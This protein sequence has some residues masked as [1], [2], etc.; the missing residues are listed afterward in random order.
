MMTDQG[1]IEG[2]AHRTLQYRRLLGADIAIFADVLVKHAAPVRPVS[3]AQAA[4]ETA[5]RGL[6]DALLVTG[7][8]TGEETDP[9]RVE[10]VKRAVPDRPVLVASG[11]TPQNIGAY[12]AA[13][14]FVVGTWL[15]KGGVTQNAVDPSRVRRLVR[16]RD[17]AAPRH[18]RRP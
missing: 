9:R 15:K 11:V 12:A 18:W 2:R 16:A 10:E 7:S 17:A 4:A 3:A 13:D 5:Y 6:A 8:A 14:G 1:L